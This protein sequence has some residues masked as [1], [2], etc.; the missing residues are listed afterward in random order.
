MNKIFSLLSLLLIGIMFTS[1]EYREYADAEYPDNMVY[2]PC[3]AGVL[4]IDA[5]YAPQLYDVPTTTG[6]TLFVIDHAQ[7]KLVINLGVVQSGI[8][9][10]SGS[11]SLTPNVDAI[12][13]LIADGKLSDDVVVLPVSAY[14]MPK[15]LSVAG[16]NTPYTL[17]VSL[18]TFKSYTGKKVALA[19]TVLSDTFAVNEELSTQ[20]IVVDADYIVNN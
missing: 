13:T 19:V 17:S 5:D 3:A 16:A 12:S 11:A 18:D 1:C 15:T 9:L 10:A 6:P 7:G 20:V 2:Q 14:E 8:E 4:N